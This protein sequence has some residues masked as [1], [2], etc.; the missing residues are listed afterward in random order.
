V[1][2]FV[3]ETTKGVLE[4]DKKK[5][6]GLE[7]RKE[8]ATKLLSMPFTPILLLIYIKFETNGRDGALLPCLIPFI[9]IF[10]SF[11]QRSTVAYTVPL[12]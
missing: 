3:K 2:E 9:C 7:K 8:E 5:I 6:F 11:E 12:R 10:Y 4:P 1:L